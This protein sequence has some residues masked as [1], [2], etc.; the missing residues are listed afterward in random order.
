MIKFERSDLKI[1]KGSYFSFTNGTI[2]D[3]C[4]L[5]LE[6]SVFLSTTIDHIIGLRDILPSLTENMYSNSQYEPDFLIYAESSFY[7]TS[8][9]NPV[10]YDPN[11]RDLAF[12]FGEV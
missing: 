1:A 6:N 11:L 10:I 5:S 12:N 2:D 4:L 9:P 3:F 7:H 8:A